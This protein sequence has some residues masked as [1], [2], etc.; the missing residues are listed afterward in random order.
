MALG[1]ML[2]AAKGHLKKDLPRYRY[3][4]E[5][6]W[7]KKMKIKRGTAKFILQQ[8][9]VSNSTSDDAAATAANL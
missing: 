9:K 7:E 2:L 3:Q 5:Q 8:H 6:R 4:Y 1:A